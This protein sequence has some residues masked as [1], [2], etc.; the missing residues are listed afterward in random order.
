[1]SSN[2]SSP[3]RAKECPAKIVVLGES[4][5]GKSSLTLRFVRREFQPNQEATIGAAFLSRSMALSDGTVVKFEIW[6]TAG[7]ERYRALAPMYYRGAAGAIVV[8]DITSS[9]S[10]RKAAN[11]ISE[12]QQNADPQTVVVLAGNKRD[13]ETLRQVPSADGE[14]IA[15]QADLF[16]S[17]VS[18]KDGYHVDE[19]FSSLGEQ[20]LSQ[21]LLAQ[22]RSSA[23]FALPSRS[24]EPPGART[25]R[26][27]E[28]PPCQC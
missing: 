5:V 24:Q 23:A 9:E 16:F 1:M 27:P 15:R 10:L 14:A 18:A 28:K 13:L 17:E 4:A 2:V 21:G 22:G 26:N 8:Y 25:R 6:D 12:L 7:Q 3:S 20:L 19:L 11:W